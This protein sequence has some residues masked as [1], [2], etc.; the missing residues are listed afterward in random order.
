MSQK[1]PCPNCG[2]SY[3]NVKAHITKSHSYI[4]ITT[5]SDGEIIFSSDD[6]LYWKRQLWGRY[7]EK[8]DNDNPD[9][10]VDCWTSRGPIAGFLFVTLQKHK[11]LPTLWNIKEI[12]EIRFK[13]DDTEIL[14]VYTK[15]NI[16][17]LHKRVD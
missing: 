14:S 4:Q 13:K 5:K 8:N 12:N 16:Q 17:V 1:I 7:G 10:S 11:S 6:Q 2:K 9:E 15:P 3:V